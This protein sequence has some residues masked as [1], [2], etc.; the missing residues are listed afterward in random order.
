MVKVVTGLSVPMPMLRLSFITKLISIHLIILIYDIHGK[1]QNPS[2]LIMDNNNSCISPLLHHYSL[3]TYPNF[4][5]SNHIY[6][7]YK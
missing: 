2:N 1:T 3:L 7:Y 6:P 4:S 5:E